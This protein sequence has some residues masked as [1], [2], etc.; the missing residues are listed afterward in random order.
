MKSMPSFRGMFADVQAFLE[1]VL[2]RM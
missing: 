2:G 1:Q